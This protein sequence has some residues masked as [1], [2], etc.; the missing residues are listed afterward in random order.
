MILSKYPPICLWTSRRWKECLS[1]RSGRSLKTCVSYSNSQVSQRVNEPS[2]AYIVSTLSGIHCRT[3][4]T[5]V[6]HAGV[7]FSWYDTH[8]LIIWTLTQNLVSLYGCF[9]GWWHEC[10][11]Y[12]RYI[13]PI[14]TFSNSQMIWRWCSFF[15][16]DAIKFEEIQLHN[17]P[18][19]LILFLEHARIL[20]FW[21]L[22]VGCDSFIFIVMYVFMKTFI[23]TQPRTCTKTHL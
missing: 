23:L 21:S 10:C 8:H 3:L 11:N 18:I 16:Y 13:C 7:T 5:L 19:L 17:S 9:G 6:G 22:D 15:I 12:L 1:F 4:S 20:Q 14:K 2:R